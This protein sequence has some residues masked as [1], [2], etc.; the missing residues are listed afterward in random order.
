M[1]GREAM[2]VWT[3]GAYTM[4]SYTSSVTT[5]ASYR[6]ASVPMAV[7]SSRVNTFPQGL[8]GLQRMMAF[9]PCRNPF[10]IS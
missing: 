5:N 10:S 6:R 2:A 3:L 1:P 7:S 4:C 9:A 8:D